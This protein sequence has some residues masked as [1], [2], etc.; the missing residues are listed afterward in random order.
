MATMS[1]ITTP[2]NQT[3]TIFRNIRYIFSLRQGRQGRDAVMMET[4]LEPGDIIVWY[5][6]W[7]PLSLQTTTDFYFRYESHALS[8]PLYDAHYDAPVCS[9]HVR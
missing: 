9:A 4:V 5:V 8:V 3:I 2:Q 1:I 6:V 7:I